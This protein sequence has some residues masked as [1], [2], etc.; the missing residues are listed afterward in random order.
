RD[1]DTLTHPDYRR[2]QGCCGSWGY[3]PLPNQICRCGAEFGWEHTDCGGGPHGIWLRPDLV[4][5]SDGSAEPFPVTSVVDP[6]WAAANGGTGLVLARSI[7]N[8]RAFGN[9][10]V[11]ADALEEGGCG[12]P[13]VLGHLRS[14]GKHR[15]GCWF[16]DE[17]LEKC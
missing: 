17:I 9:L 13:V 12:D 16:V 11:L 4:R 3:S 10:P 15:G 2:S 1:A 6:A 5:A 7:D 14:P 8:G